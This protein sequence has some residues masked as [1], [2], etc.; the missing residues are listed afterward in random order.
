MEQLQKKEAECK[1]LADAHRRSVLE[2]EEREKR[3]AALE[4]MT[5]QLQSQ[6]KQ[7]N[8]EVETK[9]DLVC[10]FTYLP[11]MYVYVLLWFFEL[12][13]FVELIKLHENRAAFRV[14]LSYGFELH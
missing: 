12:L 8:Q 5:R 3:H 4:E 14:K 11:Q 9:S 13:A 6:M 7:L 1:Q 10:V 2:A